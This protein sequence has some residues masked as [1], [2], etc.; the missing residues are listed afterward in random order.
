MLQHFFWGCFAERFSFAMKIASFIL[1]FEYIFFYI[2]YYCI[3]AFDIYLGTL[4][5]A[6]EPH[7]TS[8]AYSAS[9][10]SQYFHAPYH[11]KRILS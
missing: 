1:F 11:E 9:R 4:V 2:E 3:I 8:R 7:V 10:R 6:R 5:D